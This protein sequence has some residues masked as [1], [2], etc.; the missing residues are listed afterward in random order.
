[1]N[2]CSHF[3]LLGSHIAIELRHTNDQQRGYVYGILNR[4]NRIAPFI[5]IRFQDCDLFPVARLTKQTVTQVSA[6][7]FTPSVAFKSLYK[8]AIKSPVNY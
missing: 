8:V 5:R 4:E 3:L 6:Y 1:M 7:V 2:S